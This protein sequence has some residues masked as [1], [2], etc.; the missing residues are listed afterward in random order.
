MR[1]STGQWQA[2]SGKWRHT[3]TTYLRRPSQPF[4]DRSTAA[5][6]GHSLALDRAVLRTAGGIAESP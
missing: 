4:G 1:K 5:A 6:S 3:I 2:G